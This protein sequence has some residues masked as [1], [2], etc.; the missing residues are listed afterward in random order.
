MGFDLM[1]FLSF[2]TESSKIEMLALNSVNGSLLS[3]LEV[4]PRAVG[5]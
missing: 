1:A 5:A 4:P 2:G 3:L